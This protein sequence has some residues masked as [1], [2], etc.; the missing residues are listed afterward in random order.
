MVLSPVGGS[1]VGK[2]DLV[3]PFRPC[4]WGNYAHFPAQIESGPHPESNEELLDRPAAADVRVIYDTRSVT[5]ASDRWSEAAH[6][7]HLAEQLRT[8]LNDRCSCAPPP[9]MQ[10]PARGSTDHDGARGAAVTA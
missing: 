6:G 1:D 4:H 7:Q 10:P 5:R 2:I 9:G 8:Q 3:R